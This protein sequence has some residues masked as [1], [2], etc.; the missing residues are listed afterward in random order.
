MRF[1]VKIPEKQKKA[2][3]EEKITHVKAEPAGR[4]K[5]VQNAGAL[6]SLPV[7]KVAEKKVQK[8][9]SHGNEKIK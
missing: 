9:K 7:E 4:K 6:F 2:N 8:G 1:R 5:H 3:V